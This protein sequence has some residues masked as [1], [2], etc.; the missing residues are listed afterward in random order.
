MIRFFIAF[1]AICFVTAASAEK[2]QF[3]NVIYDLPE[4]WFLGVDRDGLQYILSDRPD[5]RCEYCRIYISTSVMGQT[6]IAKFLSRNAERYIDEDDREDIN[7]MMDPTISNSG[8]FEVGMYNLLAGG[9]LYSFLAVQLPD[10]IELLFFSAPARDQEDV[11]EGME[12]LSDTVLPLLGSLSFVSLG[13][14][15]LMPQ[16]NAGQYDGLYWGWDTDMSMGID[17]VLK[18]TQHHRHI[19]FWSEGYVYNGEP[20]EGLAMPDVPGLIASGDTDIGVYQVEGNSINITYATGETEEIEIDGKYLSD[21]GLELRPVEPL[22]DGS[23]I[24]GSISSMFYSGFGMGSGI[25][26]GTVSSSSTYFDANGRYSG[27]QFTGTTGSFDSGSG[28]DS[29]GGF[30]MSDEDENSGKYE[31]RDGLLILTPNDGSSPYGRL[32]Y[33]I[34]RTDGDDDIMIGTKFLED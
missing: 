11:A 12:T 2:R 6:D 20:P 23:R 31:I 26:G 8:P 5:E 32:I 7:I 22:A 10:R 27:T 21:G 28:L 16:P 30:S 34:S 9:R 14:T 13:A 25:S 19:V 15:P 24:T 4:N 3:S 1:A 17:G 29:G 18:T 33:R